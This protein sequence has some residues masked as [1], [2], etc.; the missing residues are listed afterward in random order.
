M[1]IDIKNNTV[2]L[3]GYWTIEN[4]KK[5]KKD[6]KSLSGKSFDYVDASGIEKLDFYGAYLIN[7]FL[8]NYEIRNL[9]PSY[10]KIISIS[11]EIPKF[12]RKKINYIDLIVEN[13]YEKITD[14]FKFIAFVGEILVN[15][16]RNIKSFEVRNLF[17]EL[18]E[19]G[20]KS[21][22]IITILSFLMGIVIT[23]QSSKI[24]TTFGANIF[25][26]DLVSISLSRELSPLI[27]GIIMA[28]R[29]ASSFTAEIGLM[30][31]SEEI[32]FMKTLGISPYAS[33]VFPKI[34]SL[35]FWFPLLI[36][37]SIILGILGSMVVSD[38]TL[39]L[40]PNQ[41]FN[42]LTEVLDFDHYLAGIVKGPIFGLTVALIG[43]YEGFK[44]QQKAESVGFSV[45]K[46]V[47]RTLFAI[48]VIDALFSV[49]YRWLD[50]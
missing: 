43:V 41:F 42:R 47:V 21:I 27:V 40:P 31:V 34:L 5:I 26:V 15:I 24:L 2:Y 48:I 13:V 29:S 45:T 49:I 16:F 6:I 44:V 32:D 19:V 10:E 23:Y 36:T 18:E 28:G 9:S 4:Y 3:K 11:K 37:Y 25:I 1:F 30:K 38:F 46:S 33:I 39:G 14:Y 20:I 17:K 35:V 22:G 7:K 12:T 8:K 50:I